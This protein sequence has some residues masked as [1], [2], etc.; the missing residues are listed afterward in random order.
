MDGHT[1]VAQHGLGPGGGH[2]DAFPGIGTAAGER[3]GD[4]DHLARNLFVFDFDVG[5][6][7][8]EAG[9]PVDNAMALVDQASLVEAHEHF[10][11][12]GRQTLVEGEP[13]P[14]PIAGVTQG[15][16]L[17]RDR[18]PRTPLPYPDLFDE[19]VPAQL[20]TG[21]AFL[22][23]F[24]LDDHLGG[25]PR[26]VGP[27][28]PERCVSL[29][30]FP[31]DD[32]VLDRVIQSMADVQHS[33]HVGGRNH[34]GKRLA[35]RVGLGLERSGL[36]PDGVPA[37]LDNLW[38]VASLQGTGAAG[39]HLRVESDPIRSTGPA[40]KRSSHDASR[41]LAGAAEPGLPFPLPRD[42]RSSPCQYQAVKEART[43]CRAGLP[44]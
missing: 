30:P 17:L 21:K 25:D 39:L 42:G 16:H 33:G 15:P 5:D 37:R 2:R 29:H 6:G 8:H 3:V 38:V 28:K 4:L 23:Q 27:R 31:P 40:T 32:R 14:A 26:M 9:R 24:S 10:A 41:S 20:M 36:L 18:A 44:P 11:D 1:R 22:G 34:D 43:S 13:L 12:R 35:I 7:G 19:P